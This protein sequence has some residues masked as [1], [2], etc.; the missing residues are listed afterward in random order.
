[1]SSNDINKQFVRRNQ[2]S[3]V[4][5]SLKSMKRGKAMGSDGIPI[6]VWNSL[7]D[8]AI[9]WLICSTLSTNRTRCLMSRGV[10]F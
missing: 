4:K 10:A 8:I 2:E 9:V 5:D 7:E 1:M 6:K 3:E